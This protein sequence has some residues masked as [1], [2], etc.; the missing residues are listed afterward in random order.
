M[1][2]QYYDYFVCAINKIEY[3]F[4]ETCFNPLKRDNNRAE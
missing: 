1:Y 4:N 3:L 2:E